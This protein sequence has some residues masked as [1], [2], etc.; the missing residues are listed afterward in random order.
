MMTMQDKTR[1][2]SK[3]QGQNIG[4]LELAETGSNRVS[5]DSSIHMRSRRSS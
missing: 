4:N 2:S 5:H 1:Q 3:A